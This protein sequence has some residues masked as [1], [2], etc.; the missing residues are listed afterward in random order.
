MIESP[1]GTGRP[2]AGNLSILQHL[3]NCYKA[4]FEIYAHIPKSAKYTLGE[5][6]DSIFLEVIELIFISQYLK[7]EQKLPALQKANTKFDALKF[8]LQLLW[9]TKCISTKQYGFLSEK[10]GEVGKMLGGWLKQ[11]L[12]AE[13]K[14]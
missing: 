11:L 6:I 4:W 8:F 1:L 13:H 5:K 14:Q 9:E 7:K 3:I 2:L 10:L 12:S